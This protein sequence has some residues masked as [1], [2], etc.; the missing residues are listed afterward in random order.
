MCGWIGVGEAADLAFLIV[1]QPADTVLRCVAI[2]KWAV[3]VWH[4]ETMAKLLC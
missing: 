2:D 4:P 3:P 1:D